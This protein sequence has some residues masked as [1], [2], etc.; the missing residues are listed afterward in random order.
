[1]TAAPPPPADTPAPAAG[2]RCP[3]CGSRKLRAVFT[4]HQARGTV[5]VR[6]C[7]ACGRRFRTVERV[8]SNAG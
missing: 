2:V 3:A 7:K 4:R 5:R 6:E 8:E 1:M